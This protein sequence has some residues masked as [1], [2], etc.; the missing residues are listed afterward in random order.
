[1]MA[2]TDSDDCRGGAENGPTPSL[3]DGV[4]VAN[5]VTASFGS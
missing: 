4:T 5:L 3:F 1:M 2:C